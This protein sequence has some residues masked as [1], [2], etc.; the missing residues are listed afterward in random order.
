MQKTFNKIQHPFMKK[1]SKNLELEAM[2]L[3]IIKVVHNKPI[4]N[5]TSNGKKMSFLLKSGVRH[6]CPLA[7][8]LCNTVLIFLAI[9]I[10]KEEEIK[11]IKILK[12]EVRLSP[13]S[14]DLITK[15]S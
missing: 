11:R 2:Y 9:A 13:L 10:R 1:A 12:E 7:P 5:I 14:H 6:G 3:N 8:H 4:V 15:R